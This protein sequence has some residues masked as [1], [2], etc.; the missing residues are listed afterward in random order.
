MMI[1][2]Q[3]EK[4]KGEANQ[5]G[6]EKFKNKFRLRG[7][8]NNGSVLCRDDF[9]KEDSNLM[10]QKETPTWNVA[11]GEST[12]CLTSVSRLRETLQNVI[13]QLIVHMA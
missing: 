8:K 1:K 7:R 9:P 11:E 4:D 2:S 10:I 5:N 3:L 12:V 13:G 6:D